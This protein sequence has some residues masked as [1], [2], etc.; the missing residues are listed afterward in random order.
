MRACVLLNCAPIVPLTFA[1]LADLLAQPP[2]GPCERELDF[3]TSAEYAEAFHAVV[4][5]HLRPLARYIARITRD[6]SSAEDIA[7]EVLSSIYRGKVSFELA[8]IYRAAKNAALS[9]L[10]RNKRKR[11]L[12]ARWA[13]VRPYG[14]KG[15][16][17]GKRPAPDPEY[18]MRTRDEAAHQA[19]ERLRYN[20]RV[21][22]LLHAAGKDYRQI[23]ELIQ[24][25]EGVARA[26]VC[27]AKAVLRRRLRAY[28]KQADEQQV[29]S[30]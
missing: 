18:L 22:F 15:K 29:T 4:R 6:E 13:G 28:L 26:R 9:E 12:E 5:E 8:Y 27:R 16:R 1:Q 10:D 2:Y 14:D 25:N 7:Q 30:A 17:A 11:I 21:P 23:A 19:V 24:T 20:L 3:L